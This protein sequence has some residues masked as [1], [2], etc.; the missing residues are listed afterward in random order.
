MKQD[1][2][3]Q[4][5]KEKLEK[6]H[7]SPN[8]ESW[9]KLFQ[10]LEKKNFAN[11]SRKTIGTFLGISN[12]KLAASIAG[13]GLIAGGVIFLNQNEKH[14]LKNDKYPI[15][16][17]QT[18][19]APPHFSQKEDYPKPNKQLQKKSNKN[20]H[21]FSHIKGE[22]H[23]N[24]NAFQ[25]A[26]SNTLET[27]KTQF[28]ERNLSSPLQ[29]INLLVSSQISNSLKL[30]NPEAIITLKNTQKKKNRKVIFPAFQIHPDIFAQT[31]ENN[32][33]EDKNYANI[34]K[35]QYEAGIKA[36][37]PSTGRYQINLNTNFIKNLGNR[38]FISTAINA[39]LSDVQNTEEVFYVYNE[40]GSL[41]KVATPQ[42]NSNLANKIQTDGNTPV[43]YGNNIFSIG[44]SP[45]IGAKI[46]NRIS[47]ATGM[48]IY[49][50]IN[51]ELQLKENPIVTLTSLQKSVLQTKKTN[52]ID[53]GLIGQV[54]INL[55]D[56]LNAIGEYRRGLTKFIHDESGKN[57]YNNSVSL[58]LQFK[59]T[60]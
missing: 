43:T 33:W 2:F 50:N 46:N 38:F 53:I 30:I 58:G 8:E 15:V 29:A 11:N 18:T 54:S 10:E 40:K 3:E 36:G 49:Q 37:I 12:Y 56:Y 39:R 57:N 35:L 16:S 52:N 27:H 19:K 14:I 22:M 41:D 7:Y 25:V 59:M 48:D 24:S 42:L 45:K 31:N 23:R 6:E 28:I 13:I 20:T 60:P 21:S 34:S 55:S 4:K 26:S 32:N 17:Q 44:I 51:K 47:L 1:N 5:I 9:N